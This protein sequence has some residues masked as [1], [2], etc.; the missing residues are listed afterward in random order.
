MAPPQASLAC[1]CLGTSFWVEVV[2][3]P[4]NLRHFK[5]WHGLADDTSSCPLATGDLNKIRIQPHSVFA[6]LLTTT[7]ALPTTNNQVCFVDNVA[8]DQLYVTRVT[9]NIVNKPDLIWARMISSPPNYNPFRFLH[10]AKL[11]TYF[12]KDTNV[13]WTSI[14]WTFQSF[15]ILCFRRS[16]F[17][18]IEISSD[19]SLSFSSE[20][21]WSELLWMSKI[22]VPFLVVI[23]EH[24]TWKGWKSSLHWIYRRNSRFFR[25]LVCPN[26]ISK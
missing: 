13:Q 23:R 6:D 25:L 1:I 24:S 21:L 12:G 22:L 17:R 18:R 26:T 3:F 9:C 19:N 10:L 20:L 4:G 16:C 7:S 15:Q 11:H 5:C 8:C 2:S 14:H